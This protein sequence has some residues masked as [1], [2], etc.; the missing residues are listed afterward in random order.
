MGRGFVPCETVPPLSGFRVGVTADRR[1]EEQAELLRRRG[2]EVVLAPVLCTRPFADDRPLRAATDALVDHPPDCV[3]ATT[4][5]GIRSW[6]AAAETWGIDGELRAALRSARIT[7]R[8]PKAAAALVGVGLPGHDSEPS[9]RLDR[10]LD[11]LVAAGI[12]GQR[13]ALQLYGE[14]PPWASEQL[15]VAGADVV[16]VPVY[17]WTPADDLAPAHHLLQDTVAGQLDALTFT[18]AAAVQNLAL[19]ADRVGV[20]AQLRRALSSKVVAACVGPVTDEAAAAVGF[21]RRCAPQRGRL[22]LLV[23]TLSR[24]L[25][26]RHRHV[27][28]AHGDHVLLLQGAAVWALAGHVVLTDVERTLLAVLAERPGAV[29]SR[30]ALRQRIWG[31]SCGDP[32]VDKAISR[33]RHALRPVGLEVGVVTRR[34]WKLNAT[35]VACPIADA[36]DVLA[37]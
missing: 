9:E 28:T 23:R 20:G 2:A 33:L 32:A 34:G 24:D 17:R 25:H 3:I 31:N 21:E 1:A 16:A 11:R 35:E 5:I 8:G 13:V 10:L 29:V 7:A 12:A 22:G 4:G 19:L 27:R 18:S 36:V 26:G 37:S 14:D 6:F 15:A 30:A